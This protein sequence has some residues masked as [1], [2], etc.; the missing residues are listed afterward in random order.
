VQAT[1]RRPL[2]KASLGIFIAD[3]N[4]DAIMTLAALLRD[5]GHVVHTCA[6]ANIALDAI[7]QHRPDVCILDIKM[8]GK[9]GYDLVREIRA[10][11]LQPEP[12]LI[13]ISGHFKRPSEQ[14][15]ARASGF[16]HFFPKGTSEPS[17]L[18]A[19]LDKL[20]APDNGPP[21]AA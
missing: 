13:A 14:L 6:N 7:R 20:A 15:V 11:R 3:D 21:S 16:D 18:L 2:Q 19:L 17:E 9:S 10:A 12:V 4:P 8:P 1:H 5:E